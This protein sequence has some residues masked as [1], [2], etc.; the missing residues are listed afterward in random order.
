MQITLVFFITI[1]FG[2]LKYGEKL[3]GKFLNLLSDEEK[4]T[5]LSR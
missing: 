5:I 4:E 1:R 2:L 3:I